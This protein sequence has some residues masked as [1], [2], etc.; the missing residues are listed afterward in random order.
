M[1]NP[2]S[3]GRVG[4]CGPSVGKQVGFTNP[5]NLVVGPLAL[6]GAR[7]I[8]AWSSTFHGDK[9]PLPVKA[10]G[11]MIAKGVVAAPRAGVEPAKS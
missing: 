11:R 5:R 6:T 7:G 3:G 9:F 8:P 10:G 2:S 1:R 4:G